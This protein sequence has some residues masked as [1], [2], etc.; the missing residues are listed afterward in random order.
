M[1]LHP[2]QS[3]DYN[4]FCTPPNVTIDDNSTAV[5]STTTVKTVLAFTS[6]A[7]SYLNDTP[8]NWSTIMTKEACVKL[9]GIP[10][11]GC[12]T[13]HYYSDIFFLSC[14]LFIGTFTL[15]SGLKEIR[16]SRFF[17]AK[18]CLIFLITRLHAAK[19]IWIVICTSIW[20]SIWIA[21]LNMY[22]F[23]R[24]SHCLD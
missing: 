20:I 5:S 17:P 15:A 16:N 12:S 21:N 22:L 2:D 11:P 14:L 19:V 7:A 1:N 18:V 9:E 6:S 4:C 24:D 13:P 10:S 3:L 23:T 8:T